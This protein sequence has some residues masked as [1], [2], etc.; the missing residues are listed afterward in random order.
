MTSPF[1]EHITVKARDLLVYVFVK[2]ASHRFFT[3]DF[4]YFVTIISDCGQNIAVGLTE[5]KK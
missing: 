5:M 1:V 3:Q 4:L 2:I